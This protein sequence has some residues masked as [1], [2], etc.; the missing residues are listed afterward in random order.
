VY[1][2]A[3]IIDITPPVSEQMDVWPG[4]TPFSREVLMRL[5]RGDP[6]NVVSVRTTLHLGAHADAPFH[7]GD[8]GRTIDA[9]DLEVYLGRCRVVRIPVPPRM[10][11]GPDDI[12]EPI[13]AE[14]VLFATETCPDP[15]RFNEDFAALS[16]GLVERLGNEGVRLVGIDTPGVDLHGEDDLPTHRAC[17][18]H[19]IAILERLDLRG[20]EAGFY[21][22]IALPLRLVGCDGSPVRAVLR[23][24]DS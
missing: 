6:V 8:E 4:D 7:Y 3:M 21:E 5:D 11:I 12:P 2:G 18:R 23:T 9:Q 22:L 14:R 13:G 17:L 24:L 19:D 10:T 15:Q 20:V 16:P 1:T